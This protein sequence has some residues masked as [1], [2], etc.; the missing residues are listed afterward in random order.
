MTTPIED[1][2]KTLRW[3]KNKVCAAYERRLRLLGRSYNNLRDKNQKKREMIT[4]LKQQ[5]AQL[6]REKEA[7]IRDYYENCEWGDSKCSFADFR[8]E[9]LKEAAAEAVKEK[10]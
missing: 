3:D 1:F 6:Q 7:I 9:T 10:K 8:E 2:D 4:E 5:L